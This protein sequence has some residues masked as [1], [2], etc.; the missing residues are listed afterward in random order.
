MFLLQM[1]WMLQRMLPSSITLRSWW[2]DA[3][4]IL[5]AAD[6]CDSDSCTGPICIEGDGDEE[7]DTIEMDPERFY[8]QKM[9]LS[10]GESL[11]LYLCFGISLLCFIYASFLLLESLVLFGVTRCQRKLQAWKRFVLDKHLR[12]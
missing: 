8:M 1:Q 7:Y 10:V 11:I 5:P 3:Q 12:L 9:H 4:S 6:H 2:L